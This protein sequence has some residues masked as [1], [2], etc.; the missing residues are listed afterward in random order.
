MTAAPN[1]E[2]AAKTNPSRCCFQ[3]V[4]IATLLLVALFP[5]VGAAVMPSIQ[6]APPA[7]QTEPRP[8]DEPQSD[9]EDNRSDQEKSGQEPSQPDAD[10]KSEKPKSE[11]PDPQESDEPQADSTEPSTEATPQEKKGSDSDTDQESQ[12]EPKSDKQA[13]GS[14]QQDDKADEEEKTESDEQAAARERREASRRRARRTGTTSRYSTNSDEFIGLFTQVID[15]VR[16]AT[17]EVLDGKRRVAL[18]AIVDSDGY[19]LTKASELSGDVQVRLADDRVF[20]ASVYG[21]DEDTDLALLKIP[22]TGLPTVE[23]VD[24][25]PHVGTW[26]VT[27][28]ITETP[29]TVGVIGVAA[30]RIKPSRAMMGVYL[31]DLEPGKKGV[32]INRVTAGSPAEQA[33]LLVNDVILAVDGTETPDRLT[34]QQTI[35]NYEPGDRII[36]KLRRGSRELEIPLT[37]GDGNQINPMMDRSNQQNRMGSTLSRRRND[38]VLAMQHDSVL[39]ADECGGPLV[40][41]DGRVIGINIARSG[42]VDTLALPA[43]IVTESL[44]HL[45]AGELDP[46][47]VN[48][49]QIE[50]IDAQLKQLAEQSGELEKRQ[51]ELDLKNRSDLAREE[52]LERMLKEIQSRLD[53]LREAREQ[54]EEE[55]AKIKSEH[56]DAVKLRERLERERKRLAT[57]VR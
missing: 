13:P 28:G 9:S 2:P 48:K 41:L 29:L 40:D 32:R 14:E 45:K 52:E 51:H 44:A 34:L 38:F 3:F 26:V 56:D 23:F 7:E 11:K 10:S 4:A 27:P 49:E 22:A 57:G 36:I 54:M 55:L 33:N 6:E 12:D 25:Q 37:L 15:Q 43:S 19:I 5:S 31:A 24:T 35:A 20:P 53:S 17:V 42:R 46:A 18:G 39:Q 50:Q 30:R 8:A 1:F 16:Q 47:T 21:V